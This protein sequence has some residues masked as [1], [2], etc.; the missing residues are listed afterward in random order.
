MRYTLWIRRRDIVSAQVPNMTHNDDFEPRSK[1][2][3]THMSSKVCDLH[4]GKNW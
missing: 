2:D 4:W 1:Y 3:I